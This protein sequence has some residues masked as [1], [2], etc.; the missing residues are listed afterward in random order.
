VV[1]DTIVRTIELGVTLMD[2][3]VAGYP[4]VCAWRTGFGEPDVPG[5]G[6][7]SHPRRRCCGPIRQE[8]AAA[9]GGPPLI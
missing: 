1:S 7:L 3:Q 9:F 6:D 2:L 5:I 8:R 4:L